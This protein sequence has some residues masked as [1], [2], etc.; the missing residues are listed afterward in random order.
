MTRKHEGDGALQVV[1]PQKGVLTLERSVVPEPGPGELVVR[2][3]RVGVCAT[4]LHLLEGHIGDRSRSCRGTSSWASSP[5][6]APWTQM[7]TTGGSRSAIPSPSRCSCPATAAT[8]AARA[9]TTT[10]GRS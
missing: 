5:P 7:G 10:A 8:G 9:A 4:D 1:F 2:V 3:A 6:S